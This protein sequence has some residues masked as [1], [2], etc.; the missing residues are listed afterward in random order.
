MFIIKVLIE[1][2]IAFYWSYLKF[3]FNK[4]VQQT[5]SITIYAQNLMLNIENYLPIIFPDKM[6]DAINTHVLVKLTFLNTD[7][8]SAFSDKMWNLCVLERSERGGK[9]DSIIRE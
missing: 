7:S 5:N 2:L 3:D 6:Y 1:T 9:E 8:F 4:Q